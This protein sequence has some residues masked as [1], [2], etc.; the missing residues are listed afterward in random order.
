MSTKRC[1]RC[2]G[3]GKVYKSGSGYSLIDS[4]GVEVKCPLCLGE[5][6]ITIPKPELTNELIGVKRRG[7]P[8]KEKTSKEHQHAD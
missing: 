8:K 5:K 1:F 3:R 6:M 4:G 7:R 2:R